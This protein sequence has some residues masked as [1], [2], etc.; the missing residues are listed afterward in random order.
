METIRGSDQSLGRKIDKDVGHSLVQIKG[1]K[2]GGHLEGSE[3]GQD[4]III[5]QINYN[6]KRC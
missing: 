6:S 2:E 3:K 4:G 5:R 1:C